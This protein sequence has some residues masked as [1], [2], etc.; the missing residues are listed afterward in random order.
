MTALHLSSR[1]SQPLLTLIFWFLPLVQYF[2]L[3]SLSLFP[4]PN[5]AAA[6]AMANR[7]IVS[8][9]LHHLS[10]MKYKT[11]R[12]YGPD[13]PVEFME[14]R[15]TLVPSI[16]VNKLW[17]DEGTSILWKRYPH[18][19]ALRGMDAKRRQYYAN[20]VEQVF[21]LSPPLGHPETLDYLDGLEWPNLKSLELEVDFQRHGSKF[22]SMLHA[23]LEH[24]ELSGCQSGGSRYFAEGVIPALMVSWFAWQLRNGVDSH[25]NHVKIL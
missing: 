19:P 3:L 5:M 14:F 2:E 18:L 17:A 11:R 15:P 16:L 9:T 13:Q 12:Q 23:R 8:T 6:T 1:H 25:R 22:A 7:H 4:A 24:V 10:D 21:S 20:K